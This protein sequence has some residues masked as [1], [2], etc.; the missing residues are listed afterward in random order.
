MSE[1]NDKRLFLLDAFAL[2]YRSYFAFSKN[3]RI[4]T[5]GRNTSAIYGFALTLLDLLRKENPTHIAI[6]F[7]PPGPVDRVKDFEA[8]KAN[9]EETPEDI[10]MSVPYIKELAKGFRIPC[11][12][13]MGYEADDVIGTL[14]KK[15]SRQATKYS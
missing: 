7:D 11:L 9:R 10:K 8:Y 15:G 5:D 2:I 6:V 3:P 12:E 1:T 13:V 4:T 14:A